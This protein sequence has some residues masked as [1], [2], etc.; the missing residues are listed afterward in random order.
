VFRLLYPEEI[1]ATV[2]SLK[3]SKRLVAV[4][5][6]DTPDILKGTFQDLLA[7]LNQA[8]APLLRE[9][10]VD[11]PKADAQDLLFL[12]YP[13]SE[14]LRAL[15]AHHPAGLVL[16]PS[17]F[18]LQDSLSSREADSLFLVYKDAERGGRLTALFYSPSRTETDS[19]KKAAFK[20]THY[21]KYSYLSFSKGM[22]QQKGTWS[23]SRSPLMFELKESQ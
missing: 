12:G 14:T 6:D 17:S 10:D 23:A 22:S 11:L 5:S 4:M 8:E 21:G 19:M 3:G 20:I 18:S 2:N 1:P 16:E 13:R 7:G 9:K 15:L